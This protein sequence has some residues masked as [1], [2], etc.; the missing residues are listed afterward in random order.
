M[1]EMVEMKAKFVQ[2]VGGRIERERTL[3]GKFNQFPRRPSG[4]Y[5]GLKE[6]VAVKDDPLPGRHCPTA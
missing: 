2:H 1:K 5:E 3:P 6:D 4:R